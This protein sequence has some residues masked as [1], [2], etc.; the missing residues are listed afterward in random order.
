M[1]AGGRAVGGGL[2]RPGARDAAFAGP[3]CFNNHKMV[4]N[5]RNA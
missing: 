4:T 3:G 5:D 2:L 1:C